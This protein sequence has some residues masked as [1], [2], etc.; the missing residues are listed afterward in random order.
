MIYYSATEDR[1]KPIISRLKINSEGKAVLIDNN[2]DEKNGEYFYEGN[3]IET[4]TTVDFMLSN[5]DN[6]EHVMICMEKS[7]G[8]NDR[9]L[10]LLLAKSNTDK[11]V[12]VKIAVMRNDIYKKIN[13]E[14]LYE[15]MHKYESS[16][17]NDNA[18]IFSEKS[19]SEY[20]SDKLF[21]L[22]KSK[23]ES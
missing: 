13:V 14:R 23:S 22:N 16:F 1:Q 4:K 12:C 17:Y 10:G 7:P 11:P 19:L 8:K 2:Y 6:S 9:Y 5:A 20:H 21:R 18:Y 3:Y 15:I